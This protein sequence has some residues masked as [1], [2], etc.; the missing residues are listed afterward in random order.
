MRA[1]SAI[2]KSQ[3]LFERRVASGTKRF[4]EVVVFVHNYG[5]NRHTFHRQIEFVNELGFDAVTFDLPATSINELSRVPLSREWKFGLRHLWADKIE[6]VLGAIAD[7]KF[8]FS[9]SYGSAAALQA[10][11]RR[12]AIDVKGW[13]CDGGPFTRMSVAIEHFVNEGF[14]TMPLFGRDIVANS[15][16]FHY[17]AFRRTIARVAAVFFG[18]A[19]YDDD[20]A[21]ALRSLPIG[22]PVLSLQAEADTLV[23]P[24]MIDELFVSGFGRIDLQ[25]ALLP[26]A[27]HLTGM[28]DAT[29]LYASYVAGFLRSRATREA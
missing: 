24:D 1:K 7:E 22:F 12:H 5:G 2:V 16:L 9:F 15:R 19:Q 17:P 26:R 3:P 10:I 29:E 18:S 28:K 25:K 21:R 20:A 8:I 6:D 13:I 27:H 11:E 14:F 4:K 23:Q